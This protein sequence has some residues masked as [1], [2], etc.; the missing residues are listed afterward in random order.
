MDW[1]LFAVALI[2]PT[3]RI[4]IPLLMASL[5]GTFSE[6]GGV[7]NIALEGILLAG[8]FAAVVVTFKT[9]SPWLGLLGAIGAGLALSV[10][11][12][13]VTVTFKADQII[14]GLAINM[15][16]LGGTKFLLHIIF[17]SSSNSPRIEG[18]RAPDWS[19]TFGEGQ[20]AGALRSILEVVTHPLA[21]VAALVLVASHLIMYNT[22]FGLRLRAVGEHPEAADSLGISVPL[23]R[24]A[25]VLLGGAIAGIGGAWLAF[26]QSNFTAGMSSGRGY[27]ALAAMIIGKWRPMGALA[28]CLFFGFADALQ[29][30]LQGKE[31]LGVTIPGDLVQMVPYVLTV[32]VLCGWIGKSTAP[33]ADGVPYE[34]ERAD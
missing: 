21:I 20:F 16:V 34:K 30:K 28:A 19:G 22:V 24:Y 9:G 18:L 3:L 25:G 12:S 7:V 1:I 15:L 10:L 4:A 2:A 17:Q 31:I 23:M 27:I 14:S 11:H 13:I 32:I 33:A 6:R 5:G 8:A 29:I 26:D